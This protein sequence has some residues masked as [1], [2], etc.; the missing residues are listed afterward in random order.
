MADIYLQ[1][2]KELLSKYSIFGL[3][4]A[5]PIYNSK[6][7]RLKLEISLGMMMTLDSLAQVKTEPFIVGALKTISKEMTMIMLT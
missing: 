6:L 7:I 5:L 2:S 3:V 1:Q 4:R